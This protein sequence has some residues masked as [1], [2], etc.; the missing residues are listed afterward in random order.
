MLM[1]KYCKTRVCDYTLLKNGFVSG[2]DDV[3]LNI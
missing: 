1:E 2:W 3:R